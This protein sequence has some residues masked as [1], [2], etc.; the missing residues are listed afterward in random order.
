M[1]VGPIEPLAYSGLTRWM[2]KPITAP[3]AN[4][5]AEPSASITGNR[6]LSGSSPVAMPCTKSFASEAAVTRQ[7]NPH[8]S[9]HSL[10]TRTDQDFPHSAIRLLRSSAIGSIDMLGPTSR[11]VLSFARHE[12][13]V[14]RLEVRGPRREVEHRNPGQVGGTT[15]LGLVHTRDPHSRQLVLHL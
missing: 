14:A 8:A 11:H 13:E 7:I 3:W 4:V 6:A 12:L 1:N 5:T 10:G 2:P 9:N 15:N